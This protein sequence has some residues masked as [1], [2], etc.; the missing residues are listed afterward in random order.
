MNFSN[1]PLPLS[2]KVYRCLTF[3]LMS[4]LEYRDV[5]SRQAGASFYQPELSPQPQRDEAITGHSFK[6]VGS[7]M[8]SLPELDEVLSTVDAAIADIRS[9]AALSPSHRKLLHSLMTLRDTV[10]TTAIPSRHEILMRF[11]NSRPGL[12]ARYKAILSG[13]GVA[14]YLGLTDEE[15]TYYE[16]YRISLQENS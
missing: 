3:F 8:K 6:I 16:Q 15:K 1:E 10:Q 11:L 14:D 4:T 9:W 12:L 2:P 13:E 5:E 7:I